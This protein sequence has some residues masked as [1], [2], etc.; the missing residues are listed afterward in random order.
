MNHNTGKRKMSMHRKIDSEKLFWKCEGLYV[1]IFL[2]KSLTN[3]EL[4]CLLKY[5]CNCRDYNEHLKSE[6]SKNKTVKM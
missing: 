5:S 6:M 2:V 1:G 3:I 4:D